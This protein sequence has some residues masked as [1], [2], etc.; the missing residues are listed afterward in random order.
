MIRLF[1]RHFNVIVTFRPTPANFA[2]E[3]GPVLSIEF[4]CY[5][6]RS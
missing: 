6:Y 5:F 4:N 1:S 3:L 2:S